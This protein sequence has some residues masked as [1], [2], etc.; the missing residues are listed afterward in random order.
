MHQLERLE[1]SP[2]RKIAALENV[3]CEETLKSWDCSVRPGKH[4]KSP[5]IVRLLQREGNKQPFV[6]TDSRMRNCRSKLQET[7]L[8]IRKCFLTM[9]LVKGWNREALIMRGF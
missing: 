3:A 2:A 8:D 6:S 4:N 7:R 9:R 1:E 5:G